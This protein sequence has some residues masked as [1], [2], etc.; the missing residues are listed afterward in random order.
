MPPVRGHRRSSRQA[1]HLITPHPGKKTIKRGRGRGRASGRGRGSS[2]SVRGRGSHKIR[3]VAA[4]RPRKVLPPLP[5]PLPPLI[6]RS[7]KTSCKRLKMEKTPRYTQR[8]RNMVLG[9]AA[10]YKDVIENKRTDAES[11][12]KKDEVWLQI[13]KEFNS[14]VYHQ[15]SAKQL[16]QLYKNMKLL[17]KKDLCGED[18]TNGTFLDLLNTLSQQ[19]SVAQYIAEQMS[20]DGGNQSNGANG[21]QQDDYEDSKMPLYEG[22]DTDVVL[23]K[24]ETISDNEQTENG[25]EC[26]DDDDDDDCPSPKAPEV[27][28]EEEDDVLFAT[29]LRQ[30]QQVSAGL[31]VSGVASGAA[32]CSSSISL[33]G[34][35]AS[36]NGPLNGLSDAV[37]RAASSPVCSTKTSISSSGSYVSSTPKADITIQT[38][39]HIRVGS[40]ANINKTL[41]NGSS[42]TNASNGNGNANSSSN[43]VG[44]QHLTAEQVQQHMLLNGLGLSA[45]NPPQQ[46]L[47]AAINAAT[48]SVSA[49]GAIGGGAAFGSNRRTPP[50]LQLPRLQRG[51]NNTNNHNHSSS[52]GS[53]TPNGVQLLLNGHHNQHGRDKATQGV[54]IGAAGSFNGYNG[55]AVTVPC[56][57]SSSSSANSS[58][59]GGI[60]MSSSN[61]GSG[62][63]TGPR[64]QHQ[65]YMMSLAIEERK[66][67][68]D[69]LDAQI[70]YWQTL[71][72]K[73]GAQ[74]G[75]FPNPA[76][77]CHFPGSAALGHVTGVN[78]C[79]SSSSS[80]GVLQ[81][82]TSSS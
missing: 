10:Q 25:M 64:A 38:V 36:L 70:D 24:S 43:S 41:Q 22:M 29:D 27:C 21:H 80:A 79:A 66:R 58:G 35:L 82:Q 59:G 20:P 52:L 13:A 57:N 63:G 2:S 42:T 56:L 7:F 67:K 78:S 39:G 23:I 55:L 71:T 16:R 75:H 32:A 4:G 12:R 72:K 46:T 5:L 50:T 19:D 61:G 73:L 44:V 14:K 34:G 74:P 28:L 76:C 77:L 1:P 31:A 68:I 9:Y 65:E 81:T 47:Q 53:G 8:E 17:L 51:N 18:K 11:N 33:P 49:S 60:L 48:A 62:N 30:L 54:A 69:L 37:P 6:G 45:V 40:F 3:T 15:R 26:L